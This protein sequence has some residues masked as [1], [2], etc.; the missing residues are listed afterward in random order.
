MWPSL[1]PALPEPGRRKLST[2]VCVFSTG[3]NGNPGSYPAYSPYVVSVGGT[4]LTLSSDGTGTVVNEVAW[5][6]SGGST[7]QPSAA[8]TTAA[9][10]ALARAT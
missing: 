7:R 8:E 9:P 10:G 6:G 3:D 1:E 4:S 2:A 5:S